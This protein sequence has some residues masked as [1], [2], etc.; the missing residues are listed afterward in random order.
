LSAIYDWLSPS[1]SPESGSSVVES[2]PLSAAA[3]ALI[4][5][6]GFGLGEHQST[7]PLCPLIAW[8]PWFSH[9][10]RPPHCRDS[11]TKTF[12]SNTT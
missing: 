1:S 8:V 12:N 7:V 10:P 9:R 11:I 5:R 2:S 4:A 3:L 6:F